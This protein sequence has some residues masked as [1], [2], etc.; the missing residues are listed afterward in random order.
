YFRR[1]AKM[2]DTAWFVIREQN[3]RFDW[4]KDVDKKRPFYF[5]ALTWYMDRVMELVHDD[6]DTYGEFLAVVHLVRPPAAL[7]TPKVAGKVLGKW[8]RTRLSGQKTLI[9]RNYENRTVPPV[10]HLVRTEERSVGLVG[11]RTH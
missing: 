8:A 11:S 5:R 6:P 2:A 3:L 1:I 4:L 10:D 7:M 9:A